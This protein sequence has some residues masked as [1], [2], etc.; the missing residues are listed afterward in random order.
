MMVCQP[1]LCL[2]AHPP[3]LRSFDL[4]NQK[5]AA[6][7]RSYTNLVARLMPKR[8]IHTAIKITDPPRNNRPSASC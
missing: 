8:L 4:K 5:I 3:Q 1:N 6:C 7:G 2:L